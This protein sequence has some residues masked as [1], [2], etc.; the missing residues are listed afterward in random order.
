MLKKA[1]KQR[2]TRDRSRLRW[3][4]CSS[5]TS[6]LAL[7]SLAASEL[8]DFVAMV[9]KSPTRICRSLSSFSCRSDTALILAVNAPSSS[10]SESA[11]SGF[12][13]VPLQASAM[14]APPLRLTR[15]LN[16]C[17]L[18]MRSPILQCRFK[19]ATRG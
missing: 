19:S 11:G 14:R 7:T 3:R 1:E 16:M 2:C 15:K 17:S 8:G 9:A 12:A 10:W 18:Y 5:R 6:T 4:T 13:A